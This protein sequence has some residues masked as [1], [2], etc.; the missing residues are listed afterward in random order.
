MRDMHEYQLHLVRE[1]GVA[2][3]ALGG[4]GHVFVPTHVVARE[5]PGVLGEL[6]DDETTSILLYQLGFLTGRAQAGAFFTERGIGEDELLYRVLT[7]P[8][9]FAWAGYGDV[10]I[11]LLEP[12]A[13]EGFVALWE[14]EN[15]FSAREGLAAGERRRTCHVQ[16][17]YSAG[18]LTA[19]TRLPLE[20]RELACR[21]E[22][23]RF[24]RF[25]VAH[26]RALPR[27]LSEI[28][29]HRQRGRYR[30]IAARARR[31]GSDPDV[32]ASEHGPVVR[33]V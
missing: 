17:G 2:R 13:D 15:S 5:L 10:D 16:A 4:L 7:G 20:A 8:F 25:L 22:G 12:D 19:A 24:C 3:V 9:H 29:F 14:T 23:V 32:P 18:W 27:R 30:V 6:L 33:L 1:A 31:A 28:R 11:L 26:E 21:T